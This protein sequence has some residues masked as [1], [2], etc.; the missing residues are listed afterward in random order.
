MLY[1]ING[2]PYIKV[3]SYYREVNVLKKGKEYV[4]TPLT[5]DNSKIEV[6]DIERN[7]TVITQLSL[8][9]YLK[10][11]DSKKTLPNDEPYME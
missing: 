3:L 4:V 5:T 2:K 9:Q 11:K 6:E 7:K 10:S 1:I 8:E